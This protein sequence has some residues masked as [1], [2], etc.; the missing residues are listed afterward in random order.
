MTQGGVKL[1]SLANPLDSGKAKLLVKTVVVHSVS[2]DRL[3][4]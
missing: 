1:T 4:T 2:D 3:Q